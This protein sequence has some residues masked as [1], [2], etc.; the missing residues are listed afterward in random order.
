MLG[1]QPARRDDQAGRG[2]RSSTGPST[3]A[4]CRR[5]RPSA[6]T[7]QDGRGRRLR[8]GRA[9]RRPAAHP[10]RAHGRGV[11]ARRPHRRPAALRHPRVQDG[12]GRPRP[13]PGP[14]AGRGHAASAAGSTSART[15]PA[16]QLRARV[17]RGRAR[18]RRHRRRATCPC[19]GASS[20]A[21]TR[22]WSTCRRPTACSR[23]TSTRRQITAE[24]KHVVIIG[25]G[26][27]GADCLGT[28]HRQ[29]ARV[30]DPAGDH[31]AAAGASAPNGS[32]G[33]P[34]R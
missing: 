21:S 30:G 20:T 19:P 16:E 27:T 24:G 14:D 1:D 28:A 11:R 6:C 31:A 34:T 7:G 22:R 33:R 26:D 29:G 32:R 17:R 13:A 9:G 3:T 8:P 5:S 12:E 23:A 4:G 2:R 18:G 10:R 15:S 25:G